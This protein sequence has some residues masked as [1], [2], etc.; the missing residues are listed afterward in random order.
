MKRDDFSPTPVTLFYSY[1]HEDEVFL[2]S[3]R[4]H[5]AVLERSGIISGWYDR[6]ITAGANWHG[7]IDARLDA[8]EIILLLLSADFLASDYCIDV[9]MA[10]ALE[11]HDAGQAEVIPIIMRECLW[12]STPLGKLQALPANGTPVAGFS[13][14][15]VAFTEIA[16]AIQAIVERRGHS[17]KSF[18]QAAVAPS[19]RQERKD[20]G[21]T[22]PTAEDHRAIED[23]CADLAK[24]LDE[25]D[26]QT[27]W[28]DENWIPID[29]EV[30][31]ERGGKRRKIDGLVRAIEKN[32]DKQLVFIEG[33]PGS[34]KSVALRRLC[35]Q[36]LSDTRRRE[37][38]PL[39]VNLRSWTV[40]MRWSEESPPTEIQLETFVF[41]SIVG[42]L[43]EQSR[44]FF[45]QNFHWMLHAGR[46]QLVLDSFDEIPQVMDLDESAQVIDLLSR[47]LR[48]FLTGGAQRHGIV[49]S[50]PRRKPNFSSRKNLIHLVIRPFGERQI[51]SAIDKGAKTPTIAYVM[52][53][54]L[55]SSERSH[56]IPAARTPFLLGLML[57]HA[58]SHSGGLPET[59]A[60]IYESFVERRLI[61][62]KDRLTAES[63]TPLD[64]IH[65]ASAMAAGMFGTGDEGGEEGLEIAESSLLK[66]LPDP[67]MR[68]AI[69]VLTDDSVRLVRRGQRGQ[70]LSF[71]HRRFQEY[72]LVQHWKDQPT[73]APITSIDRD[74]RYRDAMVLFVEVADE[75][76]AN[77]I[78]S[79]CIA[80]ISSIG[81]S[82]NSL[83]K[84][85]GD[86]DTADHQELS[87][88]GNRYRV[89]LNNLRFV[90]EAFRGRRS[91]LG[92]QE[93]ILAD[94][95]YDLVRSSY[96]TSPLI[97][98]HAVEAAGVLSED[99]TERVLAAALKSG[100]PWV[101]ETAFRAC[102]YL[103]SFSE[104]TMHRLEDI[105]LQMPPPEFMNARKDM[106]FSFQLSEGLKSLKNLVRIRYYEYMLA[107]IAL[108]LLT[109]LFPWMLVFVP[110]FLVI[111][112]LF[113]WN[114]PNGKISDPIS[115]EKGWFPLFFRSVTFYVLFLLGIFATQS[116]LEGKFLI[117][118]FI[119]GTPSSIRILHSVENEFPFRL[120]R[121]SDNKEKIQFISQF[122]TEFESKKDVYQILFVAVSNNAA[123]Q[124]VIAGYNDNREFKTVLID[125]PN[126]E[127][128]IELEKATNGKEKTSTSKVF[129]LV[130]LKLGR[131]IPIR[132]ASRVREALRIDKALRIIDSILLLTLFF[133]ISRTSYLLSFSS[134][135]FRRFKVFYKDVYES[136]DR[137]SSKSKAIMD[138]VWRYIVFFG[139][140]ISLWM[141]TA[142]LEDSGPNSDLEV[143]LAKSL[144][145]LGIV[146]LMFLT[147]Y[148]WKNWRVA[149]RKRQHEQQT[150]ARFRSGRV[151]TRA[152]IA[153]ALEVL[154][155]EKY[156]LEFIDWLEDYVDSNGSLSKTL[157][158]SDDCW[159]GHV[160]P[161]G[162]SSAYLESSVRLAKLD[163]HWMQLDR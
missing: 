81:S 137:H 115:K 25:I 29:V 63:L 70:T 100:H 40:G 130:K 45:E 69:D 48:N 62:A 5:L 8:A 37:R 155:T 7:V 135:F 131:T 3:L 161:Y 156:R 98:K 92:E 22:A 44:A 64:V 145:G 20:I 95:I 94:Q 124:W 114:K 39:Y 129:K 79:R 113:N 43:A 30:D 153:E 65:C 80:T 160:P 68:C 152:Y 118:D 109:V 72:F 125:N 146:S 74:F 162:G 1:A 122:E 111:S 89:L 58:N 150:L 106:M 41:D 83:A 71:V 82:F 18:R 104:E 119:Q 107:A 105:V 90:A 141:L 55:L 14:P 142:N 85:D 148:G 120:K 158:S 97:G 6:D 157:A 87:L 12:E 75:K 61:R 54:A 101:V 102:R 108:L 13:D 143:I 132:E 36:W 91:A 144:V 16:R 121:A 34:G 93:S 147:W 47:V 110:F 15:D 78:A 33:T 112:I 57:D 23:L 49:A 88:S 136:M 77:D 151:R 126:D 149:K 99:N 42:G 10:R 127:L 103:K 26:K 52:K 96:W 67:Q 128:A 123:K 9:E 59:Q 50:R 38:I 60:A 24:D 140:L 19:V 21:H 86:C 35:R 133:F 138:I 154:Q 163:E 28:Q 2:E 84:N 31:V 116:I 117:V 11:R 159:P 139:L 76:T 46:F 17:P 27:N 53:S 51:W 73:E 32:R 134:I 4:K 66:L 56:L